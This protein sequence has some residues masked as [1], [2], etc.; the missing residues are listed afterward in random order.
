MY[1]LHLH[2]TWRQYRSGCVFALLGHS[3]RKTSTSSRNLSGVETPPPPHL[4]HMFYKKCE[5]M[6]R[7]LGVKIPPMCLLCFALTN[8]SSIN[9][10]NSRPFFFS[11]L[12][13]DSSSE[14]KNLAARSQ[15][16][17]LHSYS[18]ETSI[19]QCSHSVYINRTLLKKIQA[20]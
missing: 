10:F 3:F 1:T 11:H 16:R 14:R 17:P 9:H 4:T 12:A 7:H 2:D 5:D 8:S 20:T 13:C 19:G 6:S 18:P 15:V